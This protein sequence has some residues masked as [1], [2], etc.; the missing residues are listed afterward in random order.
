MPQNK[1]EIEDLI[2]E[3]LMVIRKKHKYINITVLDLINIA[4][5]SG[6]NQLLTK[7]CVIPATTLHR[8]L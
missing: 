8:I 4:K 1:N 6:R 2:D 5:N 3:E 7:L